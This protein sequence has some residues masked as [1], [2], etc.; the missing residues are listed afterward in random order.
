MAATILTRRSMLEIHDF[1][2]WAFTL[3]PSQHLATFH[4]ILLTLLKEIGVNNS[5]LNK[6]RTCQYTYRLS[7]D[8][9]INFSCRL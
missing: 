6:K 9:I 8:T 5:I 3:Q 4:E 7:F 1:A 2:A